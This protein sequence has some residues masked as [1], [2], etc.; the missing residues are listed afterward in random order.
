[1][2]RVIDRI[3]ND[4]QNQEIYKGNV[5]SQVIPKGQSIHEL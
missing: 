2:R 3:L 5:N 4:L 1:M